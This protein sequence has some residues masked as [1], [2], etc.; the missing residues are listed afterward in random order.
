MAA[1][2][3]AS[4]TADGQ[5]RPPANADEHRPQRPVLLAVDQEFGEGAALRLGMAVLARWRRSAPPTE[6]VQELEL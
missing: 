1:P 5:R 6:M 2:C 4:R 3:G